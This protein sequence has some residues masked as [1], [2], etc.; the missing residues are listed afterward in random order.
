ML[1]VLLLFIHCMY[2]PLNGG[3]CVGICSFL[4]FFGV[5]IGYQTKELSF[6]IIVRA[7]RDKK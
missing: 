2:L 7:L 3:L 4:F 6:S 5:V 1:L